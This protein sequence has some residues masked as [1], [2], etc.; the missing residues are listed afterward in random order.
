MIDLLEQLDQSLFLFLNSIHNESWD[1]IMLFISGK[2]EWIPLYIILLILIIL[3]YKRKAVW[4]ILASALLIL[5]SDQIS[6]QVFKE[7]FQRYRPCHNLDIKSLVHI[8]NNKCGGTYGFVSSHATNSFAI[9]TFIGLLLKRQEM[10]WALLLLVVW[11]A[12]VSYSRIYLGVHYPS[13]VV[14]GALLGITLAW[15]MFYFLKKTLFKKES[16]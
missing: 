12:I 5:L 15:G 6:V 13:D 8:V 11:A 3:K 1:Q 2:V 14:G 10:K 16:L 7:G 9:A 4:I